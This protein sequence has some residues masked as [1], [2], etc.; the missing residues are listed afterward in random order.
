[1]AKKKVIEEVESTPQVVEVYAQEITPT[2]TPIYKHPIQDRVLEFRA[3]GYDN[4]RIA[5][6]L[7]I[8][9][10]VIDGIK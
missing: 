9:K 7:G 1:M 8:Q 4:N 2:P 10:S 5:A 3:K 6:L